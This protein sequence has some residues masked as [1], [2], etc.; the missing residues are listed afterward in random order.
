MRFDDISSRV[1][2]ALDNLTSA[3]Q[4]A[5]DY[6]DAHIM[7]LN[8]DPYVF[9]DYLTDDGFSSELSLGI[10]AKTPG[11]ATLGVPVVKQRDGLQVKSKN[12][13]YF[14]LSAASARARFRSLYTLGVV[15]QC[16]Y[17]VYAVDIFN[18]QGNAGLVI[19]WFSKDFP[20]SW[21]A[22]DAEFS[23]GSNESESFYAGNH[24]MNYFT[25]QSSDTLDVTFIETKHA[26]IINS[27]KSCRGIA[28]PSDGTV[29]EPKYYAFK[30][31]VAMFGANRN[32]KTPV[33]QSSYIVGVKEASTSLSS[34]GRSEIAKT[35][36]T[37]QKLRPFGLYKNNARLK[38]TPPK[39]P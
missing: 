18:I 10:K 16:N 25:Q 14:G 35:Q 33:A 36:V 30:L 32:L 20:M 22:T 21:L 34:S 13:A 1:L 7:D 2:G 27:A 19:P 23:I 29:K 9:D 38:G 3:D 11:V 5:H 28:M 8:E 31:V 4:I 39:R 24:Q 15:L 26:H 12:N 37:F 6:L 17:A